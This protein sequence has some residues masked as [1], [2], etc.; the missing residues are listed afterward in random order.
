MIALALDT[1]GRAGSVAVV[2]GHQVLAEISG[3]PAI[4]H[5]ARLP[6]DLMEVLAQA[7]LPLTAVDLLA[8]AAGPGSFTGLRVG[9]AAMQ[10]LAMAIG[11]P[12]VPVSTLDALAHVGTSPERPLV[13]AWLDAQRGEVF[14]AWYEAGAVTPMREPIAVPPL[15]AIATIAGLAAG[16][17][18]YFV[19]DGA[20]RY[21][22]PIVAALGQQADVASSVPR[23][24]SAI[25]L[26]AAAD[27]QRGVAPHAVAPLY[28]RRPDVEIARDRR[29]RQT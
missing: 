19:G 7:G 27:P 8:V 13:A 11:K 12:I 20:T 16:R 22:E 18:I 25:G 3:D 14:A 29:M 10:G 28:V 2:R 17:R 9:I 5:A 24:A 1:T 15:E 4:T 23:L 6:G 26:M 21:A